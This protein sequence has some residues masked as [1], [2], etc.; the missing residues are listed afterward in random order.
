MIRC[1]V[2]FREGIPSLVGPVLK[3]QLSI[4]FEVHL[5]QNKR[6]TQKI[7]SKRRQDH[8]KCVKSDVILNESWW[9]NTG[10]NTIYS[11]CWK[12]DARLVPSVPLSVPHWWLPASAGSPRLALRLTNLLRKRI[13]TCKESK[14]Q[15]TVQLSLTQHISK[16]GGID[17]ATFILPSKSRTPDKRENRTQPSSRVNRSL[18]S[19]SASCSFAANTS[20]LL[21]TAHL[22]KPL[23][24]LLV[25]RLSRASRQLLDG[26]ILLGAPSW[27]VPPFARGAYPAWFCIQQTISELVSTSHQALESPGSSCV[28]Q[29]GQTVLLWQSDASGKDEKL[30]ET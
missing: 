2:S 8:N 24:L 22:I 9:Y 18:Y 28:M 25:E 12:K 17:I 6:R 27:P 5:D 13:S 11:S 4:R 21:P 3:V 1:Y 19:L 15:Q 20:T 30:V 14:C 16:F 26:R 23:K 7:K 29:C 10:R